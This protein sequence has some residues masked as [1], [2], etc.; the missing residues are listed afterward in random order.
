MPEKDMTIDITA[1]HRSKWMNMGY[2]RRG[3][4]HNVAN[5]PYRAAG[6]HAMPPFAHGQ[7]FAVP[8]YPGNGTAAMPY[9]QY[10]YTNPHYAQFDHRY[11]QNGYYATTGGAAR[12]HAPFFHRP[13]QDR[14]T[15]GEPSTTRPQVQAT[16]QALAVKHDENTR[17]DQGQNT[18][19]MQSKPPAEQIMGEENVPPMSIASKVSLPGQQPTSNVVPPPQPVEEEADGMKRNE[20]ETA[21]QQT[22]REKA[23]TKAPKKAHKAKATGKNAAQRETAEKPARSVDGDVPKDEHLAGSATSQAAASK[24]P[25]LF[26]EDQIR[27]RKQAWDRIPMPL[28]PRRKL[29]AAMTASGPSAAGHDRAQSL[30]SVSTR[31]GPEAK[32]DVTGEEESTTSSSASSKKNAGA[33]GKAK[34]PKQVQTEQVGKKADTLQ[35]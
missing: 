16:A 12:D 20:R 22:Q 33:K 17:Q 31:S 14:Q 1:T 29:S 8:F 11:A 23:P 9:G 32:V 35:K 21:A 6:G 28:D 5:D 30:P 25:P 26:T 4:E 13:Q 18:G 15:T 7:Q 3:R 27:G 24:T 34:K 10:M 2:G 19:D